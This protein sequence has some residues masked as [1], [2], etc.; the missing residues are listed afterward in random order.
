MLGCEKMFIKSAA[1]FGGKQL[2]STVASAD[3]DAAAQVGGIL[4][5][6]H[7]L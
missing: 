6:Q 2:C 5:Q 7:C 3:P 1:G 4:H